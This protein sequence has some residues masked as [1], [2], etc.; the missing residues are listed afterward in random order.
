MPSVFAYY[1]HN[2]VITAINVALK[3]VLLPETK[4]NSNVGSALQLLVVSLN[5]NVFPELKVK[6]SEI[7][8]YYAAQCSNEEE[9]DL[10]QVLQ[11]IDDLNNYQGALKLSYELEAIDKEVIFGRDQLDFIFDDN[12]LVRK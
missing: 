4:F 5:D 12:E 3:V 1:Q 10:K 11:Y 7:A 9:V 2:E 8:S 6:L